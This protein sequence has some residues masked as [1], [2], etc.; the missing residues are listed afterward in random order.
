V[1]LD[2]LHG[3]AVEILNRAHYLVAL[4]CVRKH[5]TARG[6]PIGVVRS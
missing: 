4:V 5:Y 3:N 2:V 6:V 1:P